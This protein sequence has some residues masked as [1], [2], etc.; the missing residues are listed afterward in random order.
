MC[1]CVARQGQV[2]AIW[3][4][5]VAGVDSLALPRLFRSNAFASAC[6]VQERRQRLGG[7]RDRLL[8]RPKL[9]ALLPPDANSV[10]L[11]DPVGDDPTSSDRKIKNAG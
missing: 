11:E 8:S 7:G 5:V 3:G 4:Q 2:S 1:A 6:A 10:A 9:Q